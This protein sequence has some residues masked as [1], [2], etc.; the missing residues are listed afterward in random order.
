MGEGGWLTS[1]GS[2]RDPGGN[3]HVGSSWHLVILGTG[4]ENQFAPDT[5]LVAVPRVGV[6]QDVISKGRI[7]HRFLVSGYDGAGR[8]VVVKRNGGDASGHVIASRHEIPWEDHGALRER[9]G[10]LDRRKDMVCP[11]A[12]KQTVP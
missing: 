2:K 10:G 7:R 12:S 4:I 11:N 8:Q 5:N 9:G 3:I 1:S 6:I